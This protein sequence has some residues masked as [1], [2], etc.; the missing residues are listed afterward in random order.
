MKINL[1][2]FYFL[3]LI[4]S[5]NFIFAGMESHLIQEQNKFKMIRDAAA[6]K[7]TVVED[8]FALY[9]ETGSDIELLIAETVPERFRADF[10][11]ATQ[12]IPEM[13]LVLMGMV[14]HE[15]GWKIFTGRQNNNGTR[16]HGPLMI[17]ERNLG[18]AQFINA[19]YPKNPS[20]DRQIDL[21]LTGINYFKD[22]YSRYGTDAVYAYN[23]G[24][25]RYRT[26]NIP[27][28]TV[29]YYRI[30]QNYA[31]IYYNQLTAIREQQKETISS[32]YDEYVQDIIDAELAVFPLLKQGIHLPDLHE[33][34]LALLQKRRLY[35]LLE[36]PGK[37]CYIQTIICVF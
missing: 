15:S 25:T 36:V 37:L 8:R 13:R 31:G 32:E 27:R 11:A 5:A 19:Y 7:D 18:S 14:K 16:D 2:A 1:K 28:S 23:C 26:G 20:G 30:V 35:S 12:D 21:L 34:Y 6:R 29:A 24:L 33:Q 10:L 3:W 22:L 9:L 4:F 17:N